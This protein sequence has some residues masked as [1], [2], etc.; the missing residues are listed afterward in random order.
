MKIKKIM[1]VISNILSIVFVRP[2]SVISCVI[3]AMILVHANYTWSIINVLG[4]LSGG[5]LLCT[6]F[7]LLLGII[8]SVRFRRKENYKD[9]YLIQL[10]PFAS[11][12]LAIC[13]F[14]ITVFRPNP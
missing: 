11:V 1:G 7:F 13:L 5:F 2:F 4:V 3:G 12:M 9:S 6:P 10:L 8:L 14:F